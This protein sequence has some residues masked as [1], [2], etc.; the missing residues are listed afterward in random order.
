MGGSVLSVNVGHAVAV[1]W[2]QDKRSTAI[3]KRPMPGPVPVSRERVGTDEHGLPGHGHEHAAVYAYAREDAEFWEAEL[4]RALPPGVFGEN[5]TTVGLP[6]SGAVSGE[7]WR[8]GST[9]LQVS[10]PR[11]P[12]RTFAGW[13]QVPDLV[14]RFTAAGRPGAYLR[15]LEPGQITAGDAVELVDR[16][17][18][19]VSVADLLAARAGDRSLLPRVRQVA[20][21]PVWKQWLSSLD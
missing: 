10:V 17:E 21:P 13:W 7:R 20:L 14:K 19:G 8:V 2:S 1:E 3:D 6:V 9:L 18:H 15:V 5:L 16:P 12:C 4:G 11:I